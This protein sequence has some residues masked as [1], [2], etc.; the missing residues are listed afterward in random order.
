MSDLITI[1]KE[2]LE[3]FQ[4]YIRECSK[5]KDASRDP[6]EYVETDNHLL[7]EFEVKSKVDPHD[8]WPHDEYEYKFVFEW[9]GYK[10]RASAKSTYDGGSCPHCDPVQGNDPNHNIEKS[11]YI[12][13]DTFERISGCIEY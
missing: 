12:T 7:H 5:D 11:Y 2:V 4:K 13:F 6:L 3:E 10:Y 8:L 1:E 9:K